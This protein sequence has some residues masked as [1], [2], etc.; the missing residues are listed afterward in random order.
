MPS[1]PASRGYLPRLTPEFYR[2]RAVV[3]WTHPIKNRATGWLNMGFHHASREISLHATVRESL[4]CPIYTLMPD[5]LHAVWMGVSSSSD[6]QRTAAVLR[7]QF[8]PFLPPHHLQH[9]A[10]DHVLREDERERSAFAAT[11]HYIAN[12]PV[13]AGRV[14]DQAAWPYTGCVVPGYFDLHLLRS[15]FW[16][17]FWRIYNAVIERGGFAKRGA[18]QAPASSRR[19]LRSSATSSPKKTPASD[20][21]GVETKPGLLS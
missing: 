4:F 14:T 16:D 20:E 7:N 6:R 2:G 13:R 17:K 12:N 19:P 5:H 10:Y 15:D 18:P 8:G 1:S 9:Q 3:F 21:A 11:C